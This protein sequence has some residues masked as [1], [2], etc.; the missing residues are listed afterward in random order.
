MRFAPLVERAWCRGNRNCT[1]RFQFKLL[2][3]I[4]NRIWPG[5]RLHWREFGWT[6]AFCGPRRLRLFGVDQLRSSAAGSTTNRAGHG[7]MSSVVLPTSISSRTQKGVNEFERHFGKMERRCVW[8]DY[9]TCRACRVGNGK[10]MGGTLRNR[11]S[12]FEHNGRRTEKRA[13]TALREMPLL[14]SKKN[15]VFC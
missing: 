7:F 8:R 12:D 9:C 13:R 2:G 6:R 4:F 14:E 10:R 3:K 11:I 15:R 5:Y 1:V